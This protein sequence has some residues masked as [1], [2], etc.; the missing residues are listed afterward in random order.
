MIDAIN[1]A[2]KKSSETTNL[3]FR[4]W[5]FFRAIDNNYR[6]DGSIPLGKGDVNYEAI[7]QFLE[8]EKPNG[9]RDVPKVREYLTAPLFYMSADFDPTSSC[10]RGES[11]KKYTLNRCLEK[12]KRH[13]HLI[14]CTLYQEKI[15]RKEQ[16]CTVL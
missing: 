12:V 8:K 5:Y 10:K 16:P 1:E 4:F 3:M 13:T 11:H 2:Q 7:H 14:S 9:K 6:R 15:K